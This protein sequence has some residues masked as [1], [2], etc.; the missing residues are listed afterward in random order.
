MHKNPN[1]RN[2]FKVTSTLKYKLG[3][4]VDDATIQINF[5]KSC[6]QHFNSMADTLFIIWQTV[7]SI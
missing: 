1:I 2:I 5:N 4:D 6:N 3:Y 7:M